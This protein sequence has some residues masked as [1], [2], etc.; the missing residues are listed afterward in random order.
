MKFLKFDKW[1]LADT[2]LAIRRYY[3]IIINWSQS[4]FVSS[5]QLTSEKGN[6]LFVSITNTQL[7][8]DI[9]FCVP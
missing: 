7:K 3:L 9:Y 8:V 1:T 6:P 2:F 4:R 5:D